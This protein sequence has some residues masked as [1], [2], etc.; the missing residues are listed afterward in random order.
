MHHNQLPPA[1][2]LATF[3][4]IVFAMF[5]ATALLRRAQGQTFFQPKVSGVELRENWISGRSSRGFFAAMSNANNCLWFMVTADVFR[6][7][8]HFPFNLFFPGFLV[9]LD[10]EIPVGAITAVEEKSRF[11][12]GKWVRVSYEYADRDG[13][14]KTAWVELRPR[15][16]KALYEVLQEKARAARRLVGKTFE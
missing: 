6:V 2:F 8:A 5:G 10:L 15:T 14:P 12:S 3:F 13:R 4:G 9:R 11:L 16:G 7:G 1:E